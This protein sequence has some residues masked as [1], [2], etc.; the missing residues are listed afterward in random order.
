MQK[1]LVLLNPIKHPVVTNKIWFH[2]LIW[3]GKYIIPS[4]SPSQMALK[5]LINHKIL[6]SYKNMSGRFESLK[7]LGTLS[8]WGVWSGTFSSSSPQT[9]ALES[10]AHPFCDSFPHL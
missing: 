8:T 5:K 7:L 10:S 3:P 2:I 9:A 4:T 6:F 1:N